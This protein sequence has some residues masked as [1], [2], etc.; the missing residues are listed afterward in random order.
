MAE[1]KTE[2]ATPKKREEARKKGHVAR[3][4][5][6]N[7]A[8]VLI[9]SLL[10]LSAFEIVVLVLVVLTIMDATLGVV[11]R[12]VPQLNIFATGFPAKMLV[13]LSLIG[14]SLPFVSGFIANSLETTVLQALHSLH[15]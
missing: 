2:K 8:V 12:V 15:P 9:A 11:S 4:V 3:S 7:G 5:D 10:A 14:V 1:N 13:G 6:V